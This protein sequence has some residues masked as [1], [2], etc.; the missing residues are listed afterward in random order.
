MS[1]PIG[2]AVIPILGKRKSGSMIVI[3]KLM[4]DPVQAL[5][6]MNVPA[7]FRIVL[8]V[9]DGMKEILLFTMSMLI[10]WLSLEM[11]YYRFYRALN[12][13]NIRYI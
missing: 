5:S 9:E 12:I 4:L 1:R 2:I 13:C 3:P 11:R 10:S 7:Q 8:S 6:A